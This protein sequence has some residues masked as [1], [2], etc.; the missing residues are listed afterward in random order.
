M[1][2]VM[3]AIKP[4]WCELIIA[5]KKTLEIR[6]SHPTDDA[7]FK[8]YIY[9]TKPKPPWIRF[10]EGGAI[11]LSGRVI[12]EF[13][14][15][16]VHIIG[17]PYPAYQSELPKWILEE[18]QLKYSALHRYA[19]ASND[20]NLHGWH[21]SDLKVYDEPIEIGRFLTNKGNVMVRPP[22]S[23]CYVYRCKEMF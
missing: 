11:Q 20:C 10:V 15:D 7:P 19:I 16:K 2:E 22:Q 9:A 4:V 3:I 21:I 1:R 5:G 6:K 14:C 17:V 12:G 23:W 8:A 13:I 18:S